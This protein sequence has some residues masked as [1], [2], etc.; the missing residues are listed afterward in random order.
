[1]R[2]YLLLVVVAVAVAFTACT[3]SGKKS[4]EGNDL[5]QQNIEALAEHAHDHDDTHALLAVGGSCGMCTDRIISTV[6]EIEGVTQ[7]SYDLEQQELHIHYLEDKTSVDAI[8]K[9]LAEV[10]HDTELYKA[11]DEVYDALPGCCKYRGE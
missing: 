1:M 7:A 9:A 2:K 5:S 6:N 10:G 3:S 11:D 4:N 8:S